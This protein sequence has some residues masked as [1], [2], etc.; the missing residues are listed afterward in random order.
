MAAQTSIPVIFDTDIGTD[1]DD[2]WALA[3][4]LASP[5]LDLRL[6]VTDS[7]DTR[8]RAR[9]AARFLERSGRSDVPVGIGIAGSDSLPIAQADWVAGYE[10]ESYPGVIHEDGVA[11]LI[12]TVRS[13]AEPVTIIVVGPVA[14]IAEALRRAPDIVQRARVV[15]MS[16]SVD[17]GYVGRTEPDAEYNVRANAAAARDMY[18]ADWDL[19]IAPL[20]TAGQV[21]LRGDLYQRLLSV[22][23]P[24]IEAL[25]ENYRIWAPRFRWADHDPDRESSVLYDALAVALVFEEAFCDI[26]EVPLEVTDDGFTRR[27]E[28][29]RNVRVALE[30]Q[31]ERSA[32]EEFLVDRLSAF[33]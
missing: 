29:A 24:M 1:I 14:N 11:A 30:W 2:T 10:L 23:S 21:Q 32:F 8:T 16:G 5:E 17:R 20:D 22:E 4:I 28:G 13:S 25:L 27:T 18:R 26:E 6:V 3:L 31:R 9:L 15:A 12:E 7:G 33:E 19:L